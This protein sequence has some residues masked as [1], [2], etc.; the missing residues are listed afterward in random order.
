MK[1]IIGEAKDDEGK[2]LVLTPELIRT[3][4]SFAVTLKKIHIRLIAEGYTI[5]ADGIVPPKDS[6]PAK[7]IKRKQS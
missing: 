4:T 1:N 6:L 2:D 5:T 3:F 7:P